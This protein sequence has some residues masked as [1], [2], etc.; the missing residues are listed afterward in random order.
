MEMIHGS[1]AWGWSR[2]DSIYTDIQY[3]LTIEKTV[4]AVFLWVFTTCFVIRTGLIE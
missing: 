3:P 4:H 1:G 2:P